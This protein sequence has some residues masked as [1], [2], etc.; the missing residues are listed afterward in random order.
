VKAP[1]VKALV[2]VLTERLNNVISALARLEGDGKLTAQ[3]VTDLRQELGPIRD[4][5]DALKKWKDEEDRD[6]ETYINLKRDVEELKKW[7]GDQ[8]QEKDERTRRLWSFGPN[9]IAAL[10]SG[11]ITLLGIAATIA[12]NIWL[13]KTK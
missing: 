3:T 13:N 10:I 6:R 7:K 11:F 9:I 4:A 2:D 8:K 1:E 5:L 12:V